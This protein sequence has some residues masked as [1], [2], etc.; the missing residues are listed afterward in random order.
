MTDQKRSSSAPV[1]IEAEE[2]IYR[3]ECPPGGVIL[4][5]ALQA[6][7]SL[8]YSCATGICGTCAVRVLEGTVANLWPEAPGLSSPTPAF[9]LACQSG[10]T[11]PVRLRGAVNSKSEQVASLR[12]AP[13]TGSI[14]RLTWPA[15]GIAELTIR[16][17]SPLS[18]LP[19]QYILVWFPK[20]Q[21][22]RALSV[23]NVERTPVT[24]ARFFVRPQTGG[25]L[26]YLLRSERTQGLPLRAFGPL[27]HAYLDQQ[28]HRQI[29]CVAGSTGIA[30]ML[31]ILSA[32]AHC[33]EQS[34]ARL[35]YGVRSRADAVALE[36]LR[37]ISARANGR[38]KS[39]V[40]LSDPQEGEV[41]AMGRELEGVARVVGGYV[42]EALLGILDG[43]HLDGVAFVSGPKPMVHATM[44]TLLFHGFGPGAIFS[45]DF[46]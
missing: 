25:P 12:P 9:V 41:K 11:G 13:L 39:L 37:A 42:H 17:D 36:D 21:G 24:L 43:W 44:K 20:V 15:R 30:P 29:T 16:L 5:E 38:L 3:F 2:Q 7:I 8:A 23:A 4:Y 26:D 40:A 32:W 14:A 6:G 34:P 10:A 46:G 19:G 18:F 35:V 1:I 45:D 27:G 28:T 33:A 22:P 31:P